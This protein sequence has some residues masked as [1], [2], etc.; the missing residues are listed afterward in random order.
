MTLLKTVFVAAA[1]ILMAV[2]IFA[3]VGVVPWPWDAAKAV[4]SK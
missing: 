2:T 1:A 3:A 4:M